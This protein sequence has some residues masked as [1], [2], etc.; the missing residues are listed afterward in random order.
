[1]EI[2]GDLDELFEAKGTQIIFLHCSQNDEHLIFNAHVD[3][4]AVIVALPSTTDILFA[5]DYTDCDYHA[6][7]ERDFQMALLWMSDILRVLPDNWYFDDDHNFGDTFETD[8]VWGNDPYFYIGDTWAFNSCFLSNFGFQTSF[9]TPSL[10]SCHVKLTGEVASCASEDV[11]LTQN[12][13]PVTLSLCEGDSFILNEPLADTGKHFPE[14]YSHSHSE[15]ACGEGPADPHEQVKNAGQADSTSRTS[16]VA[17]NAFFHPLMQ[18]DADAHQ[19]TGVG[20]MSDWR[21]TSP[22]AAARE[23]DQYIINDLGEVST[24]KTTAAGAVQQWTV[25]G[26]G[27]DECSYVTDFDADEWEN[28]CKNKNDFDGGVCADFYGDED[29]GELFF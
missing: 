4:S 18:A 8:P 23:V 14:M 7:S 12:V 22:S 3:L 21:Y 13:S 11:D 25:T 5:S 29:E 24:Q 6:L 10:Y 20:M 15:E 28:Q 17:L 27:L 2:L 9:G 19:E 16:Q 26:K 1:M